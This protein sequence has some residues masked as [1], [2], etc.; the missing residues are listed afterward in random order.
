[1]VRCGLQDV[2]DGHGPQECSGGHREEIVVAID[3]RQWQLQGVR[4][5]DVLAGVHCTVTL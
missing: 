5:K 2:E 1:M 4:K 3:L